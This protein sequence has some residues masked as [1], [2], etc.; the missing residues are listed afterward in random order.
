MLKNVNILGA[1]GLVGRELVNQLLLRP[2]VGKIRVFVRRNMDINHPGF[3][4]HIV[5]FERVESWKPFLEGDILFSTMGTTLKKAGSKAGQYNVDYTYQYRFAEEA[6]RKGIP[7]Y[8]LISSAGASPKSAVFYSR[9]K[10]ELDEAVKK[11]E[12]QK[13]VIL[14][15]SIL[16]GD[17]E[18]KRPLEEISVIMM[19]WFTRFI[20]R[21]YRPVPASTVAAA[22]INA[23]LMELPQQNTIVNPGEVFLLAENKL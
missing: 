16:A 10:G 3:E 18:K 7:V 22:M 9:I 20:F 23:A 5:D 12:F 4:Q 19:R 6:S 1:T 21:K 11:L 8:I 2:D 17:R 13:I 15:P 14:R